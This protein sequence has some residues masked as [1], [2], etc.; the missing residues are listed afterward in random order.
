MK[1]VQA[2][3]AYDFDGTLSPKNMQEYDFIPKLKMASSAFW[4][5]V[6]KHAQEQQADR[7]LAYMFEMLEQAK[8]AKVKVQKNNFEEYGKSVALFQGVDT[9]FDRIDEYAHEHNI[10]ID[11]FI[12]SSGIREMIS[13]TPIAK[14]FKRIFASSFMYD[15]YGIAVWP[16]LALNYTAKTQYLFR[17]KGTLDI[18]DD[19]GINKYVAE[20]D[21]PIPF[22][23]MIFIGD[24]DTDVP[25]FRLVKGQGG[26]SIAVY[27]SHTQGAKKKV[28]P[29]I[30]QGRVNF[31]APADYGPDSTLEKI[32]RSILDKVITD[33]ALLALGKME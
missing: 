13:G 32:V 33:S 18:N 8:A 27:K 26:H 16:A 14:K 3:I 20:E 10:H 21:R 2:A 28:E 23:H 17:N 15:H 31:I 29:L 24:G 11:H 7:V 12:I 9:W 30:Q 4:D 19:S 6:N 22:K 5:E 1:Q 25:C